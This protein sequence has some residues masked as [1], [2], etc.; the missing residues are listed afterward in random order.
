MSNVRG[1]SLHLDRA[2]LF[3]WQCITLSVTLQPTT[4]MHYFFITKVMTY[5]SRWDMN[6]NTH[7]ERR[8]ECTYMYVFDSHLSP[9]LL[10]QVR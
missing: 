1:D 6:K 7:A 9:S 5:I 2:S 8:L 3:P 10:P 4:A